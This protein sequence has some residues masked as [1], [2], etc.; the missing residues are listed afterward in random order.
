MQRS[1]MYWLKEGDKNTIFFQMKATRRKDRKSV[2]YIRKEEGSK[3]TE[4]NEIAC[5]FTNYFKSLFQDQ[6]T[7]EE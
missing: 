3:M 5:E 6:Q 2:K 4:T 1:R 7:G